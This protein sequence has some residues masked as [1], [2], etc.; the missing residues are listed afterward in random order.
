MVVKQCSSNLKNAVE[1]KYEHFELILKQTKFVEILRIFDPKIRDFKIDFD[2]KQI[3]A[4]QV[5]KKLCN[6][7]LEMSFNLKYLVNM[8]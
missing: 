7:M 3:L 6:I 5:Y 1:T 4:H 8:S 2:V